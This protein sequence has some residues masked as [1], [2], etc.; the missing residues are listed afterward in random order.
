MNFNYNKLKGKYISKGYKAE[1]IAKVL[2]MSKQ[3]FYARLNNEIPFKDYEILTIK[4]FLDIKNEEID[5][6]FFDVKVR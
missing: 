3:S 5:S 4:N 2:N 6:I 1:D